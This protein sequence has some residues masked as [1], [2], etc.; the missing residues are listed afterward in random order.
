MTFTRPKKKRGFRGSHP[1]SGKARLVK[2]GEHYVY[3]G[4]RQWMILMTIGDQKKP[5]GEAVASLT[6]SCERGSCAPSPL[7]FLWAPIF[8]C[9]LYAS[10]LLLPI[11]Q[12]SL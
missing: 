12:F 1:G 9:V 4:M 3:G 10:S 8:T 2:V 6:V 11:L 7:L 5:C